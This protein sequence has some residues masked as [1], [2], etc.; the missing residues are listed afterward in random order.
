MYS[1]L[2]VV[3]ALTINTDVNIMCFHYM[4]YFPIINNYSIWNHNAILYISGIRNN[5][6][7]YTESQRMKKLTHIITFYAIIANTSM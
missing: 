4:I 3:F 6:I 1:V 7:I 5:L 2:K